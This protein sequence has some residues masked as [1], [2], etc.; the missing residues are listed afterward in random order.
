MRTTPTDGFVIQVEQE[1]RT[2]LLEPQ[3]MSGGRVVPSGYLELVRYLHEGAGAPIGLRNI[4]VTSSEASEIEPTIGTASFELKPKYPTKALVLQEGGWTLPGPW[5]DVEL[6][7]LDRNVVIDLEGLP[8]RGT[9]PV[10]S[11]DGFW[12]ELLGMCGAECHLLSFALEGRT[13]QK[14]GLQAFL[15]ELGRA[16]RAAYRLFPQE[17]L[18]PFDTARLQGGIGL[19]RD[20]ERYFAHFAERDR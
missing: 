16:Y 4:K 6:L 15:D 3:P 14:P 17:Q 18:S 7:I 11:P 12:A 1:N 20:F 2:L 5:V 8:P 10:A 19:I 13:S 9:G